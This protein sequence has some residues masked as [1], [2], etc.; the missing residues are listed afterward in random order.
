MRKGLLFV[1][2]FAVLA[3][4]SSSSS[5]GSCQI[6]TAG[7]TYCSEY[8]GSSVNAD[9]V[10]AACTGSMGTYGASVCATA[11]R[12]GRCTYSAGG[13][14]VVSSFYSPTTEMTGQQVCTALSG[15]WAAN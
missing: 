6:T 5:S 11:N 4:C 1:G 10:R 2:V 12:V 7:T 9:A 14:T 13:L 15:T 3:A 8:S